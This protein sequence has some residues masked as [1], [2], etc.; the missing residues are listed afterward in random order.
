[1]FPCCCC[2]FILCVYFSLGFVE[3][4]FQY[5]VKMILLCFVGS[6]SPHVRCSW[7]LDFCPSIE[8]ICFLSGH[9]LFLH[10]FLYISRKENHLKWSEKK[11]VQITQRINQIK[12]KV[13]IFSIVM[14]FHSFG[15]FDCGG[16]KCREWKAD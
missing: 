15:R 10:L 8:Y 13:F 12:C 5:I 2:F 1:M 9:L 16:T 14:W 11:A 4:L 3:K 7:V 6:R